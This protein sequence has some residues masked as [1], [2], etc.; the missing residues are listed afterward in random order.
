MSEDIE[1]VPEGFVVKCL[2]CLETIDA[3][4]GTRD[5]FR[6]FS[7]GYGP[8][9]AWVMGCM[10]LCEEHREIRDPIGVLIQRVAELNNLP[11]KIED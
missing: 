6:T 1:V 2:Y 9:E 4:K 10:P 3:E 11:V 8:K 5:S 7:L